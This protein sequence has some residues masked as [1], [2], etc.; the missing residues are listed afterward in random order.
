MRRLRDRRQEK[1]QQRLEREKKERQRLEREERALARARE[2]L[3][4]AQA[5]LGLGVRVRKI[6]NKKFGKRHY[7]MW[8]LED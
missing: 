2:D 5:C 6:S 8:M 3:A 4:A 7:K 1:E